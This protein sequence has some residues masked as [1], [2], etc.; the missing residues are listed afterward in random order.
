[1][2]KRFEGWRFQQEGGSGNRRVHG[3]E[4]Y[5]SRSGDEGLGD[6][7]STCA[8]YPISL[9][10]STD[11][12][13]HSYHATLLASI[14]RRTPLP[15]HVRSWCR[16]FLPESFETGA[17]KV[18]FIPVV[19]EVTGKYPGS[20]GPA[21]YDRLLVIGDG[22]DWDQCMVMDCDQLALLFSMELGDYLLAAHMQGPGVDMDYAMRVSGGSDWSRTTSGGSGK[23]GCLGGG[24]RALVRTTTVIDR[25]YRRSGPE[26]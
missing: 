13:G 18:E 9:A 19:E 8:M 1:V 10:L 26:L 15:V 5:G 22:P 24:R 3:M 25:R 20:S 23:R 17:L 21:A 12:K 6:S 11:A 16:V 4:K 14:L 2:G 7:L